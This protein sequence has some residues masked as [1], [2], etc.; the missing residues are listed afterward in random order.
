MTHRAPRRCR[1]TRSSSPITSRA[2][3]IASHPPP[4][5][6]CA[7]SIIA[8]ASWM[9]SSTKCSRHLP[10]RKSCCRLS[11]GRPWGLWPSNN[12]HFADAILS[13]Y[14]MF[15]TNAVKISYTYPTNTT[16]IPF[17][18][19]TNEMKIVYTYRTNT[20]HIPHRHLIHI[21]YKDRKNTKHIPCKYRPH[22][23][24]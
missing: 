22:S 10:R 24:K 3:R 13:K 20:S 18:Y 19:C 11:C 7:A 5:T 1:L 14:C 4:T 21:L 2:L 15:H 12:A 16:H 23:V 9:R 17:Q 6:L 8:T